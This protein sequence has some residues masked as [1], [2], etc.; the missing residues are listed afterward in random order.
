MDFS[1][2]ASGGAEVEEQLRKMER[3]IDD[4]NMALIEIKSNP[5]KDTHTKKQQQLRIQRLKQ[6]V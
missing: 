4:L 1:A 2:L 5:P 3:A 6:E